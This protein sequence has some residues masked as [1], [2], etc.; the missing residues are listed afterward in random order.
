MLSAQ[1]KE[2]FEE[3]DKH[4]SGELIICAKG[5]WKTPLSLCRKLAFIKVIVSVTRRKI[6]VFR[7]DGTELLSSMICFS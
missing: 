2:N 6:A 1:K 7:R 5:R 3:L 4:S